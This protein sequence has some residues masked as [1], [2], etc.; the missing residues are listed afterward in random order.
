MSQESRD[1]KLISIIIPVY[2]AEAYIE[3]C[4]Q[5]IRR[6]SYPEL[7]IIVVN[8]GST[9]KSREICEEFTEQDTRIRIINKENG[10]AAAAKNT[11]LD[12]ANGDFLMFVDSD[13][14]IETDMIEK[15][16]KRLNIMSAE[17]CICNFIQEKP[18]GVPCEDLSQMFHFGDR[19]FSGFEMLELLNEELWWRICQPWAK[20][21]RRDLFSNVRFPLQVVE[22]LA[23]MHFLYDKC[24]RV[25]FADEAFYHYVQQESSVL[26]TR[27]VAVVLDVIKILEERVMYYEEKGYVTLIPG[28]ELL[29]YDK[30]Q[31][32]CAIV[33]LSNRTERERFFKLRNTYWKVLKITQKYKKFSAADYIKRQIISRYPRFYQVY[34]SCSR[35]KCRKA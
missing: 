23:V 31:N 14:Y 5:S 26:H 6:Q 13:D 2:N 17:I 16:L 10:G 7:E 30:I 15:M 20:L 29:L 4:I 34:L 21:Y 32:G 19:V 33:D 35:S 1:N 28:T 25:C 27:Q 9:D 22:D 12:E 18:D 8:D 3:K 24:Q 11:G